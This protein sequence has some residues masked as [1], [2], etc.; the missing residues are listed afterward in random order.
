MKEVR[1]IVKLNRS[2]HKQLGFNVINKILRKYLNVGPSDEQYRYLTILLSSI[3]FVSVGII[4]FLIYN[5]HTGRFP[6]LIAA[7]FISAVLCLLSLYLLLVKK[8]I[9][10]SAFLLLSVVMSIC[11][12]VMIFLGNRSSSLSLALLSPVLSVFLLG[13][14]HGSIFSLLYFMAYS[15]LCINHIGIWNPAPFH[16]VSYV[17]LSMIYALLFAF[18]CFYES[19]RI[20]SHQL[21]KESN[22]KLQALATTDALTELKNR[23]FLEDILLNT[24]QSR[25]F[26]ML[27]IDNFKGINDSYGHDVGDSVLKKIA[28]IMKNLINTNGTVARWGGEEFAILFNTQDEKNTKLLLDNIQ[29]GIAEY[30][31]GL[32]RSVTVSIGAGV[33]FPEDHK[34]SLLDIDKVLY[35][36]KSSG[37]NCIRFIQ[38]EEKK[39][40]HHTLIADR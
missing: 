14:W 40:D 33:F 22:E 5:I 8:Q 28:F 38:E 34:T 25:Y 29:Q 36:A 15:W 2:F 19:S 11:F 24:S 21:L 18:A 12:L 7:E 1:S 13:F 6:I 17:Q 27:D 16:I 10:V 9:K 30:D 4:G 23:R 20:K 37:K 31:F 35:L 39:K 32:G 26:A 3:I